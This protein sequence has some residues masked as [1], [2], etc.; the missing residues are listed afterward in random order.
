M[1]RV[2]YIYDFYN[3]SYVDKQYQALEEEGIDT[4]IFEGDL[5]NDEKIKDSSLTEIVSLLNIGDQL[6]VY[7]IQCLGKAIVQLGHFLELLQENEIELVIINK[8]EYQKKI[9]NVDYCNLIIDISDAE[10]KVISER[11]S[12]GLKAA[13]RRG[14]TGGRPKISK[15]TVERIKNLYNDRSYTLREIAEECKVSIGTAYKYAQN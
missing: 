9:S 1:K 6:V 10:K 5:E 7:E 14:K 2:G 11:T 8:K 4:I 15:E 12:R 3:K 13:R